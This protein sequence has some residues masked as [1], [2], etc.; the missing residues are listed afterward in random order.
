[1]SDIRL[2]IRKFCPQ[3][4]CF[5]QVIMQD[6]NQLWVAE[7]TLQFSSLIYSITDFGK[8]QK[9]QSIEF[10]I[11]Q[12]R[13]TWCYRASRKFQ[14]YYLREYKVYEISVKYEEEIEIKD[15]TSKESVLKYLYF[16]LQFWY[17]MKYH[18]FY[19]DTLWCWYSKIT[20]KVTVRRR[21]L[22]YRMSCCDNQRMELI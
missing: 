22:L 5:N 7:G 6:L 13:E 21:T 1:M 9:Y 18:K 2:F 16:K 19:K 11:F 8:F 3:L 15:K 17:Y 4:C 20:K 14:F 12:L 10:F